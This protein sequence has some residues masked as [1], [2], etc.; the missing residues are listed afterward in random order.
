M[1]GHDRL[2]GR[3]AIVTG[4]GRGI[5]RGIALALADEA[6]RVLVTDVDLATAEAVA[7]ECAARHPEGPAAA[8]AAAARVDVTRPDDVAG[9]L[10]AALGRWGGVDVL[11]CN[12][13]I[14]SLHPFFDLPLEEWDR[15]FA[16]NARGV[17]LCIQVVGRHMRD[18]RSGAIVNVASTG[19]KAGRS[20][21]PHY[22]ASK[23]AVLNLTW[24]AALALAP[25][26]VRCNAVCPGVI[27]T[28]MNATILRDMAGMFGD[29]EA[30][31]MRR[32]LEPVPLGRAGT[33]DDVARLVVFLASDEAA[34]ITGQGYNVDGGLRMD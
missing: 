2:R 7:A 4:A 1:T 27:E 10:E 24:S 12:A 31:I 13:G 32:R 15:V 5:G 21:L 33:P 19:A 17:F 6:A 8:R 18:R 20:W 28:E 23:A 26:G 29:E 14:L 25:Y 11:V 16:V 9:M 3:A 30:D 34:Y 22:N